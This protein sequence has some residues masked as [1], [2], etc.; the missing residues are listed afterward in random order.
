MGEYPE[1]P[2]MAE[3][4]VPD[5]EVRLWSGLFAPAATP[6]GIVKKLEQQLSAILKLPDVRERLQSLGVDPGAGASQ[7]FAALIAAETARWAAI[8]KA[9]NIKLD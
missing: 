8:A 5:L 3:A 2:T 7:E 4:G 9:A 6:D 1:V